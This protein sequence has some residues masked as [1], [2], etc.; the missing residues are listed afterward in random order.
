MAQVIVLTPG[1]HV[2]CGSLVVVKQ[3][4][5]GGCGMEGSCCQVTGCVLDGGG[6]QDVLPEF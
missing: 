2:P 6:T 1:A 4:R 5:N 3:V